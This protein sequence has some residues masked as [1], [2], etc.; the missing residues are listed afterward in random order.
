MVRNKENNLMS[1]LC[2]ALSPSPWV[3]SDRRGPEAHL[4][5]GVFVGERH[6]EERAQSGGGH[7]RRTLSGRREEE[8]GQAPARR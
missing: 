8:R 6:E 5:E 1:S 4:R 7:H 3:L 2:P